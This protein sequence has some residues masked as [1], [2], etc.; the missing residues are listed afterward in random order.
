MLLMRSEAHFIWAGVQLLLKM[1]CNIRGIIIYHHIFVSLTGKENFYRDH[2]QDKM[3][4][5]NQ[6]IFRTTVFNSAYN[7]CTRWVFG[8]I[9][10]RNRAQ[11]SPGSRAW[12]ES[13]TGTWSIKDDFSYRTGPGQENKNEFSC[14]RDGKQQQQKRDEQYFT[15]I[16]ADK[17]KMKFSDRRQRIKD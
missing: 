8:G 5:S 11:K 17:T 2:S 1:L 16:Q 13:C 4:T 7:A 10:N 12:P 9:W 6:R 15:S 14:C 3:L